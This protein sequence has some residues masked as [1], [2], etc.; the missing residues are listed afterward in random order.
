MS[1]HEKY[2]FEEPTTIRE[3]KDRLMI[4]LTDIRSIE[5]QLTDF[6]RR[7]RSGEVL[8][9]EEYL[10]WRSR[11]RA[12]QIFKQTEYARLK[13]WILERRRSIEAEEIDIERVNDARDILRAARIILRKAIDKGAPADV[14]RLYN[15]VDQYL[16]HAA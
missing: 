13:D 2:N 16:Y 8:S 14:G 9:R 10:R 4:L 5:K 12:S 1:P 3:A 15:V 6:E 11:T 7:D